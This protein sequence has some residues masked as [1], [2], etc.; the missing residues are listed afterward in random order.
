MFNVGYSFVMV[1]N[2]VR[3]KGRNSFS[4][5]MLLKLGYILVLRCIWRDVDFIFIFIR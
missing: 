2:F 3:E 1:K 4:F 5:F